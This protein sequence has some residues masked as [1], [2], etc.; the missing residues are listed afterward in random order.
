MDA[1]PAAEPLTAAIDALRAHL[2]ACPPLPLA[3]RADPT[4]EWVVGLR[5]DGRRSADAVRAAFSPDW[6]YDHHRPTVYVRD[7]A[8][9]W[10]PVYASDV[11]DPC[12]ALELGWRVMPI[13]PSDPSLDGLALLDALIE[14][15]NALGARIDVPSLPPGQLAGRRS[16]LAAI[17]RRWNHSVELALVS[18][19]QE[20]YPGPALLEAFDAV[21]L[22]HGDMDMFHL[23]DDIGDTIIGVAPMGQ[24]DWFEPRAMAAG[25][26]HHEGVVVSFSVP[27]SPAPKRT[28]DVAMLIAEA[29]QRRLGGTVYDLG[30]RTP[31]EGVSLR[32]RVRDCVEGLKAAGFPPGASATL[33]LF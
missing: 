5:F 25:Q 28:T 10:G 31:M 19:G 16:E 4:L 18:G 6:L 24:L 3:F 32:K 11:P 14:P 22:E 2:R 26:E 21:G 33:Q 8:G 12:E 15:A 13:I 9:T 29:L 7:P 1:P 27:R 20:P 17:R 30:T 23:V